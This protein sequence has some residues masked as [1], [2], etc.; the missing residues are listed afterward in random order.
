MSQ[1]GEKKRLTWVQQGRH[2]EQTQSNKMLMDNKEGNG[3]NVLAALYLH[4]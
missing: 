2:V 1:R 3:W 4:Y